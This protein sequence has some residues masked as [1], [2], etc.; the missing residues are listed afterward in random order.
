MRQSILK[1]V[2]SWLEKND[3]KCENGTD[4]KQHPSLEERRVAIGK[5]LA[6]LSAVFRRHC[7]CSR[8]MFLHCV[9]EY[10]EDTE[11]AQ[12]VNRAARRYFAH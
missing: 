8:R 5:K 4:K 11:K 12:S 6:S 9:D 7:I 1:S 2:V 3:A 10:D